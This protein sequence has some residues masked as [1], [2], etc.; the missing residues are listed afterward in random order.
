[1][2]RQREMTDKSKSDKAYVQWLE[3]D[4]AKLIDELDLSD[5]QKQM[6]KTRW[7]DQVT[8]FERQSIRDRKRYYVLRLTAIIGGILI[9]VCVTESQAVM[10][11]ATGHS[12]VPRRSS[13]HRIGGGGVVQSR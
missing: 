2:D 10:V 8:W 11:L 13:D 3:K 9:P 6:L 12:Y 4:L 7:L 1:M 5:L